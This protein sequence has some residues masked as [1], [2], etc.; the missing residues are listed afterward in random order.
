LI[1]IFL[2][3]QSDR[4]HGTFIEFEDIELF[5]RKFSSQAVRYDDVAMLLKR[6]DK[7]GD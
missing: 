2:E 1:D 7:D 5:L 6:F 4:R 3:I